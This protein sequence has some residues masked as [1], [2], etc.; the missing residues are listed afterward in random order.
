MYL[1]HFT[2]ERDKIAGI[3][4]YGGMT[5][6]T[7]N[8]ITIVRMALIPV[9]LILM[10]LDK[11]PW[12]LGVFVAACLS[13]ALDGFIARHYDQ[14]TVF[15]K[16]MDPL[17]DKMLVIAAMCVFVQRGQMPG[18]ALAAIVFREMAVSGVRMIAS[19]QGTVI[20]AA[21][22]GKIKT[23][24]TM[25]A[26]CAMTL[27]PDLAAV[28]VVCWALMIALTLISGAEYLIRNRKIFLQDQKKEG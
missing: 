14:I 20:A 21:V 4:L 11:T 10:Y 12:A 8:R 27:F 2:R 17:A 18:W 15:G 3:E 7:A 16:F 22:S 19:E 26:L 13:D 28:N 9:Y 5:L 6:T 25:A 24:V 1:L 23:A